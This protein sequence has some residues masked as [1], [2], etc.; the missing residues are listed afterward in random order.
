[1]KKAQMMMK[2]AYCLLILLFLFSLRAETVYENPF[3]AANAAAGWETV[4]GMEATPA[5]LRIVRTQKGDSIARFSLP[6][7]GLSNRVLHLSCEAEAEDLAG[8]NT[9]APYFGM[10]VQLQVKADGKN[11]WF[12]IPF[13]DGG[14]AWTRF[15]TTVIVPPGVEAA[16][17]NAGIQ[18]TTGKVTIRNLRVE[19]LGETL[20]LSPAANMELE[21]EAAGD[22]KG[23]WTDQGPGQDGRIFREGLKKKFYGAIPVS[24]KTDG[25]GVI[26]MKSPQLPDMPPQVSLPVGGT[27]AKTLYLLHTQAY[28]PEYAD[29]VG[30]ITLTGENAKEQNI[31]VRGQCDVGEWFLRVVELPNGFPAVFAESKGKVPA[32]VYLSRFSV[33]PELGRI[34]KITFNSAQKSIWLILGATLSAQD[35][36]LPLLKKAEMKANENWLPFPQLERN[37]IQPGSALDLSVWQPREKVGA[38]GRV[39][40]TPAG[41]FAFEKRPDRPVRFLSCSASLVNDENFQDQRKIRELAEEI[42]KNGYNMVRLH[43]LDAALMAGADREFEFDSGMLD[44][45]DYFIYCLKENG[46]YLNIDLMSSWIGYMPGNVYAPENQN[47]LK[48]FKY[49]IHFEPEIR[50]HW[51]KG[52]E[53]VFLRENPYTK[54]RLIDDPVF[55]MAVAYNEQEYG[56]WR[57]FSDAPILPLW[58]AF[59]KKRYGSI[60]NLKKAWGPSANGFAS[61]DEIPGFVLKSRIYSDDDVALF[62]REAETDTLRFYERTMREFGYPG[63]VVGYNCGKNQ[64][65]NMIRKDSPLV[66]MNAYHAHPSNWVHKGSSISQNSAIG[67]R[68]KILRDFAAVR[69]AGKPFVVTEHNLVFWNQ[70]RY[71]QAFVM[72]GYAA[73]QEFD[74]LNCF[75]TPV[76]FRPEKRILSFGLYKDPIMKAAEFMTWFLF[77][78]GDVAAAPPGIRVRIAEPDVFGKNGLRGGLPTELSLAAL[79]AG[80]SIDCDKETPLAPGE[81]AVGMGETSGIL[82]SNAGFSSTLDNPDADAKRILEEFRQKKL[83]A[84]ENRSDGKNRFESA[85]GELLLDASRNFM[86][87]DTPRFQGICAEA[88]TKTQLQDFAIETMTTRGALALVA[89]DGVKPIRQA[90]RMVLVYATNA[91][92][93]KMCFTSPDMVTLDYIGDAPVLLERGRFSVT[94]SNRNGGKLKLYPLDMAGRRLKEILPRKATENQAE[95]QIDTGKDGAAVF[96]EISK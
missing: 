53:K 57:E 85:T 28:A 72:G 81:T 82:I 94:V 65:Y 49:R 74:A 45:I 19:V 30:T 3:A 40:I 92:N 58:R 18:G 50:E 54:T 37:P 83:L 61:F 48:S 71:E 39:I 96:F 68:G 34:N 52:V 75:S 10:K 9:V 89:I 70:Y 63:P 5:G 77:V 15:D 69:Q 8:R 91:L 1:M 44:K 21:D 25:K 87:I 6:V 90:D 76:S 42:R 20:D 32:A 80:L 23:G 51:K 14:F 67:E 95:F 31:S 16:F 22:G 78:R 26:V 35:A 7:A 13:P 86:R 17:L 62:L 56:F 27:S 46:I 79:V 24:V 29:L 2:N 12:D 41:H 66:A 64:Y 84:P 59:L 33:N 47:P 60:E 38:F 4:P 88:G 43:F 73:L 55:A 11:H 36:K 93:N